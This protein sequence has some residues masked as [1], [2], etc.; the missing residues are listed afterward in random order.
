MR[1]LLT[2][3]FAGETG[4][5]AYEIAAHLG[6]PRGYEAGDEV[7]VEV[8]FTALMGGGTYRVS[9]SLTPEDGTSV[10]CE[11]RD[12]TVLYLPPQPGAYGVARL[13]ARIEVGGQ[14]LTEHAGRRASAATRETGAEN[15]GWVR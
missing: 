8:P 10:L 14:H 2:V 15:R 11:E 13:D 4:S 9:V 1:P 5:I 6:T 7:A 3:T 12:R